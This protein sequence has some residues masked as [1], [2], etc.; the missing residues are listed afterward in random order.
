MHLGRTQKL[1]G[2]TPGKVGGHPGD[3]F[4]CVYAGVADAVRTNMHAVDPVLAE[5]IRR[6]GAPSC[7]K[8]ASH[9][10]PASGRHVGMLA[11]PTTTT[12]HPVRAMLPSA[13][14]G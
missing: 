3:A 12:P 9:Y 2:D 14:H 5:Y 6:A 13:C 7:A 4:D 1:E 10:S 11:R 8:R